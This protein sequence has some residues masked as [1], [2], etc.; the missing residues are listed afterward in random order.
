MVLAAVLTIKYWVLD[1]MGF[2][3]CSTYMFI[4]VSTVTIMSAMFDSIK[5]CPFDNLGLHYKCISCLLKKKRKTERSLERL[6]EV[7]AG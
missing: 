5:M 7:T 1:I 4:S 6:N 3:V 2:V